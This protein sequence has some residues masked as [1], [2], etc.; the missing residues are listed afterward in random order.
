MA[1]SQPLETPA[2][3]PPNSP[4][5]ARVTADPSNT[6]PARN[7][8]RVAA[9]KKLA[10]Q[11]RRVRDALKQ[12]EEEDAAE[13][14]VAEQTRLVREV[15]K[16]IEEENAAEAEAASPAPNT[17]S[18]SSRLSLVAVLGIGT[19]IVSLLGVYYQR[20]AIMARFKPAPPAPAPTPA[21]SRTPV[22]RSIKE[23]E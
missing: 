4:T 10:E 22:K 8:G 13:A 2:P 16:Q 3:T 6:K 1:T 19:L 11:N 5:P 7:P 20:E 17:A 15:L 23:M 21:P 12:I 9:G 14:E 18:S